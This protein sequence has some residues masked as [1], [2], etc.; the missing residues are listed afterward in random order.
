V[1]EIPPSPNFVLQNIPIKRNN[2][3]FEFVM[4][5]AKKRAPRRNWNFVWIALLFGC[6]ALQRMQIVRIAGLLKNKYIR[7]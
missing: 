6:L 1:E 2:S 5:N 7:N 4:K 3:L